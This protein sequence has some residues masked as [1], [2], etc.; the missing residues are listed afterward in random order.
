MLYNG[1]QYVFDVYQ[2]QWYKFPAIQVGWPKSSWHQQS[3]SKHA[4][5]VIFKTN[6]P[7]VMV[8]KGQERVSKHYFYDLKPS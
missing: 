5:L 3:I 4:N 8:G 7:C 1:I 6:R 2:R